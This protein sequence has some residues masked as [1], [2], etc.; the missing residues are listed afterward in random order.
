MNKCT[1]FRGNCFPSLA[2]MCK[3]YDISPP[4]YKSR[5]K[6]EWSIERSLTTP[7]AEGGKGYEH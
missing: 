5:I 1:D 3:A 7:L 4:A 2:S 6:R